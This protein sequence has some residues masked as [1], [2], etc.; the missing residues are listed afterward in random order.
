MNGSLVLPT[1]FVGYGQGFH[2]G[3]TCFEGGNVGSRQRI[4]VSAN[5][6]G[7]WGHHFGGEKNG[8][9]YGGA[10]QTVG[11]GR[12]GGGGDVGRF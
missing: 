6:N 11:N 5:H 7:L 2:G 4:N 9:R 8:I 12:V 10:A 1:G 3:N